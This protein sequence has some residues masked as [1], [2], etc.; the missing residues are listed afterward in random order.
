MILST[1]NKLVD[2]Y[3]RN[4]YG[5]DIYVTGTINHMKFNVL[6]FPDKFLK[7][8]GDYSEKYWN[9][10]AHKNILRSSIYSFFNLVGVNSRYD[11][12]LYDES[13]GPREGKSTFDMNYVVADD[14]GEYMNGYIDN[15]LRLLYEFAKSDMLP[16]KVRQNTNERDYYFT[17]GNVFFSP[18]EDRINDHTARL[19]VDI[20][21]NII[22][23][24]M[25]FGRISM[26][27]KPVDV[28][29]REYIYDHI[30][31]DPQIS[32]FIE[33]ID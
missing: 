12:P 15:V 23:N 19:M 11:S 29:I 5:V 17:R 1:L 4:K 13:R 9:I 32:F 28:L 6:V 26:G 16:E 27:Y 21:S 3:F 30:E 20:N 18:G 8:G 10:V 22:N 2:R 31:Y 7:K 33:G 24:N 25:Y 14:L